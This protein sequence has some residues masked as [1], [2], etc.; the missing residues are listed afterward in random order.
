MG[1]DNG[2]EWVEIM[3]SSGRDLDLGLYAIGGGGDSFASLRYQPKGILPAG[4]CAVVGGP[5]SQPN[6]FS[7]VFFQ[8]ESF[9]GGLQNGGTAADAVGIFALEAVDIKPDSLT[10]DAF[11]YGGEENKALFRS[12]DGLVASVHLSKVL[13]GQSAEKIDGQWVP[14]SQPT[15]GVCRGFASGN[16]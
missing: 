6:N 1:D 11:V 9:P 7:P 5:K 4:A 8:A 16:L 2:L 13:S 3:N 10:L 12:P 15:P 14:Q